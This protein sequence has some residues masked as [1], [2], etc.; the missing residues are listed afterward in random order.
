MRIAKELNLYTVGHITFSVGLDGTISEGMNEIAHIFVLVQELVDF[1]RNK[2]LSPQAWWPYIADAFVK[3]NSN[4]LDFNNDIFQSNL[5]E[6]KKFLVD[7]LCASKIVVCTTLVMIEAAT[8]CRLSGRGTTAY[9][10]RASN[11]SQAMWIV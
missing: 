4:S 11:T 8:I 3:M 6:R 9:T 2:N 10:A 7:K 5:R 1:D